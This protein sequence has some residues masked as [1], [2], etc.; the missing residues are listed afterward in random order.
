MTA[1]PPRRRVTAVRPRRN[2]EWLALAGLVGAF[3]FLLWKFNFT[4]DD[5]YITFRYA[6]NY[7]DGHGLVW[8][9]GERVEGYTNFLWLALLIFFHSF[10]APYLLAA[11]TLG[12]MSGIAAIIVMFRL[13]REIAPESGLRASLAVA[14]LIAGNYAF[15]YWT[16]A[17]LETP[18][19][20]ALIFGAFL[21]YHRRSWLLAPLIT[22]AAL[23]RPE[24]ALLAM[25]FPLHRLMATHRL[26]RW[27]LSV[28]ALAILLG[29]PYVAF[30]LS[31]FGE[32][33]PNPFYAKTGWDLEQLRAGMKYA[34]EF[35]RDFWL[36]GLFILPAL[37]WFRRLP[38]IARAALAFSLLY[39]AYI[40]VVGGDVLKVGRFF[41]PVVGPLALASVIALEVGV[42]RAWATWAFAGLTLAAA[43]WAPLDMVRAY[44]AQES[45]FNTKMTNVANFLLEHGEKDFS[46]ATPTIGV[47]GYKLL[48]H[49]VID[50]V[51]L[52]DTAVAR[53]P[54]EPIPGISS[55]WRERKYNA[56]YIL[57]RAPNYILFSTSVKPSSP[58]ER[59]LFLY[60]AFL[61]GYRM[62]GFFGAN[63]V[64]IIYVRRN[65]SI[66]EITRTIDAGFVQVY[67]EGIQRWAEGKRREAITLFGTALNYIPGRPYGPL[68][69]LLGNAYAGLGN[70]DMAQRAYDKALEIDSGIFLTHGELY[71]T[72]MPYPD[73]RERALLHR[74]YVAREAPWFLPHLDSQATEQVARKK[75]G[76]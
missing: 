62:T 60:P 66:G 44:H 43:L 71:V 33:I 72:Y 22:L 16:I 73:L 59:A 52:T 4:Q 13:A 41:L 39:V 31:Y 2:W 29:L 1:P 34:W 28:T 26:P 11:K 8:N 57:R 32:L 51:G 25:F 65:D 67:A 49:E 56:E 54:Q 35:A 19:F 63:R 40:V 37:I 61:D 69:H 46:V 18:L 38:D 7:A 36:G 20:A 42:R 45:G 48:G 5:S 15:V 64:Q 23:T 74:A 6:A 9:I 50:M 10:G 68:L 55:S 21:L 30:K 75:A 27:E 70:N 58:G 12:A 14:G 53:H 47:I 3:L 17:G 76:R 24:G